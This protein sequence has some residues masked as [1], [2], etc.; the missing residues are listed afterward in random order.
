[1]FHRY[2][3]FLFIVDNEWGRKYLAQSEINTELLR[4][5]EL[6]K[7]KMKQL[8]E[9]GFSE[10]GDEIVVVCLLHLTCEDMVL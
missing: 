3:I 10:T 9:V 6:M 1:L 4:Q 8:E 5:I 7:E 2:H